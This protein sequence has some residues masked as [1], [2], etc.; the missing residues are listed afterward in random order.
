MA[1]G[2]GDGVGITKRDAASVTDIGTWFQANSNITSFHELRYFTGLTI[3]PS[4]SASQYNAAFYNCANLESITIPAN[5]EEVGN[6]AFAQ[7]AKLREVIF[8]DPT[9]VKYILA[10]A[11]GQCSTL[12]GDYQ[13]PNLIE[14][15]WAAFS[16]TKIGNIHL[17]NL[18]VISSGYN[19]G[20]FQQSKVQSVSHNGMLKEVQ[21]YAFDK[22]ANLKT[23]DLS[24]VEK[25]GYYAFNECTSLE[26]VDLR[27]VQELGSAF[28]RT[29]NLAIVI[30]MPNLINKTIDGAFT[31]SGITGVRSIG[32]ADLGGRW[33]NGVFQNCKSLRFAV[34]GTGVTKI[35]WYDFEGCSAL[36]TLVCEA[37]TP[38]SLDT[39]LPSSLTAIYVPD[40]S[41]EAYKAAV[42]W[43]AAAAKI[44]GISEQ[45]ETL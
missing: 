24:S 32:L 8:A 26:S 11:F 1:N 4:H 30:D 15:G 6:Y 22:C 27:M 13:F 18:T 16:S 41:V 3:L 20:A 10:H 25:I 31:Y 39:P 38:P 21:Q 23:I 43:N 19:Q 40:A 44:K 17:G 29:T 33:N 34:L 9:K 12:E 7:D 36:Q 45:T 42:N 5:V 37:V 14:I 35:S 2:V 28:Q